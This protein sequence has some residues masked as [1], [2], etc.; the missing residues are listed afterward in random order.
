MMLEYADL[1]E[2][3]VPQD[4]SAS[5]GEKLFLYGLVRALQPETCVETGTHRGKTS[6][7]IL[8]AL[9]DNGKGLLYTY[10]PYDWGQKGNFQKFPELE[11]RVRCFSEK[12]KEMKQ[13]NIDFAFIDGYHEKEIVLEEI[14]VLLPRLSRNAIVVFHDCDD[15]KENNENLVNAA[16]KATGLKT[17]YVKSHNRMR[18]YEHG[19]T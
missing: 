3:E 1:I 18:I 12:G 16:V 11:K 15:V 19:D 7:Y 6:L 13:E 10:D 17:I 5:L 4:D 2:K 9:H 8:N 14:Q